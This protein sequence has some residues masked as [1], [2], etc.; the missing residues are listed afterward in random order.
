MASCHDHQRAVD[1]RQTV[2]TQAYNILNTYTTH[3]WHSVELS[4]RLAP[5]VPLAVIKHP[6]TPDHNPPLP[7]WCLFLSHAESLGAHLDRCSERHEHT[8]LRLCVCESKQ[9]MSEMR[10]GEVK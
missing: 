10:K 7:S 5:Q 9:C 4:F 6:I 1:A 3:Y 2:D 8:V